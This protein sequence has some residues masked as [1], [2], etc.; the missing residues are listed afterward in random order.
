MWKFARRL[1]SAGVALL[2]HCTAR[3]GRAALNVLLMR[4]MTMLASYENIRYSCSWSSKFHSSNGP[5]LSVSN[6][7]QWVAYSKEAI[8]S[9]WDSL[10]ARGMLQ[11]DVI[12]F[13]DQFFCR[14]TKGIFEWLY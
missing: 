1:A 11:N 8:R 2:E 4:E 12:H 13:I 3:T 5:Q 9:V 14:I 6:D 7:D 10:V